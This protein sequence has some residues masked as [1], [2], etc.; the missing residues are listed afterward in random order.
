[1]NPAVCDTLASLPAAIRAMQDF[2]LQKLDDGR[3]LFRGRVLELEHAQ[4][5]AQLSRFLK[6]LATYHHDSRYFGELPWKHGCHVILSGDGV[7]DTVVRFMPDHWLD[8]ANSPCYEDTWSCVDRYYGLRPRAIMEVTPTYHIFG[9]GSYMKCRVCGDDISYGDVA[10]S[11]IATPDLTAPFNH[12]QA[13]D[14]MGVIAS[15]KT[16]Q[17]AHDTFECDGFSHPTPV[18]VMYPAPLQRWPSW[19]EASLRSRVTPLPTS[20]LDQ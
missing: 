19:K 6:R 18:D 15:T 13:K 5:K 20:P 4:A 7:F 2:R 11:A 10:D 8:Y 14:H 16:S 9:G 12:E 1:M 17:Y 3:V